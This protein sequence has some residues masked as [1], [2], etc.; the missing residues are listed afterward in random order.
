MQRL[1]WTI[2]RIKPTRL[3]MWVEIVD[4]AP[5]VPGHIEFW[6]GWEEFPMIEAGGLWADEIRR[7]VAWEREHEAQQQTLI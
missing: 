1:K 4:N 7:R 2:Y 5:G 3:G 6:I